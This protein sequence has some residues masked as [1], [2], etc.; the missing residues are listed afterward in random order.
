MR[1][2]SF[3]INAFSM[4]FDDNTDNLCI[5]E[6]FLTVFT[7]F[8]ASVRRLF[9]YSAISSIR[10]LVPACPIKQSGF[11][12]NLSSRFSNI[13]LLVPTAKLYRH[14]I[15]LHSLFVFSYE[16]LVMT[17]FTIFLRPFLHFSP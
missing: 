5:W 4:V 3:F 1:F 15:F 11:C 10:S 9:L 8:F 13:T 14:L 17:T 12:F 6:T 16:S 2:Q 7:T